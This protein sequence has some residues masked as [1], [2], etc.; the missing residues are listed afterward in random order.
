MK[1]ISRKQSLASASAQGVPLCPSVHCPTE[2][3]PRSQPAHLAPSPFRAPQGQRSPQGGCWPFTQAL[4]PGRSR[5]RSARNRN[6]VSV[7]IPTLERAAVQVREKIKEESQ[8]SGHRNH[9]P[10]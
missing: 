6:A 1:A 4:R 10:R 5:F 3:S 2:P 8:T 7:E 9:L